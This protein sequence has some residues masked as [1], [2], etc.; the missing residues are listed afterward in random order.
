M[1]MFLPRGSPR[2][3]PPGDPPGSRRDFPI[4]TSLGYLKMQQLLQALRKHC[5]EVDVYLVHACLGLAPVMP[6][7][8]H[9]PVSKFQREMVVMN[10]PDDRG[11]L[12]RF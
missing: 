4:D 10:V 7:E 8:G 12:G 2:G 3:T 6:C 1:T 5:E 11:V 9:N